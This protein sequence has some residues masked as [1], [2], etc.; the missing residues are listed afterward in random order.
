MLAEDPN[1]LHTRQVLGRALFQKGQ[2]DEAIAIFERQRFSARFLGY[3]YARSG[4]R[5]DA[6]KL[7]AQH[8]GFPPR[9]VL[10]YA[11]LGDRDRAFEALDRMADGKDR[12]VGD[13]L[14]YPE[15]DLLR[16]DPRMAAFRKKL[17]L[18]AA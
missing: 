10:I 11:G 18:P 1:D 15:V 5:T 16:G 2:V 6:E 14:S 9:L 3:A 12:R 7:A 4:R 17:R 8:A 13:Y